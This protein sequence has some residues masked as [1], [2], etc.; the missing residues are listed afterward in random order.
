MKKLIKLLG[1]LLGLVIIAAGTSYGLLFTS[2]ATPI[3]NGLIHLTI[4]PTLSA[5]KVSY[6]AP[7]KFEL[8]RVN[9]TLD[10]QKIHIPKITVWLNSGLLHNGKIALDSLLIDGLHWQGRVPTLPF[11]KH[12]YL[13]QIA[14]NHLDFSYHNL[15]AR[16][17]NLQVKTPIWVTGGQVLPYGHIQAS[18]D[19]LYYHGQAI[20]KVL[21][22]A[23][24]QAKDSTVYGASFTWHGAQVSG[25]AEQY[26][27]GWSL[28]NV[29]AT[30]LNL[31]SKSD[32]NGLNKVFQRLA[33]H[34]HDINSLDILNSSVSMAG[35]QFDNLDLSLENILVNQP[36]W[37]QAKGYLS[38]NADSIDY[39]G[40]QLVQPSG[41]L[42]FTKNNIQIAEFDS[43][44]Q[45]GKVQI[46]GNLQPRALHL[47]LL[48]A[49]GVKWSTDETTDLS[50]LAHAMPPLDSVTIDQLDLENNQ[51]IQLTHRP[52]WQLSGFSVEGSNMKLRHQ[53]HWRLWQGQVQASASS[54]NYGDIIGSHAIIDTHS[55]HGLWVLDRLSVPLQ[56][57]YI[58]ALGRWN[59]SKLGEPWSLDVQADGLPL[60]EPSGADTLPFDLQGIVSMKAKLHGQ[61]QSAELLRYSLTGTLQAGLRD[62]TLAT[63]Q[64]QQEA[65]QSIVVPLTIDDLQANADRGRI[66]INAKQISSTNST[67]QFAGVLDLANMS[68]AS[69]QLTLKQRC[70]KQQLNLISG[71]VITS[72]TCKKSK[73]RRK[74]K[75]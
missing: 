15:I 9:A 68:D 38:F 51:F 28:V 63:H 21:I 72:K 12:L 69:A 75:K 4:S 73:K 42:R 34:I 20:D 52:F 31:T 41:Q 39:R 17:I 49:S 5:Q 70:Q 30:K 13:Y 32:A 24:Y 22:N 57:G 1:I 56:N 35:W 27:A 40:L 18:A 29:T 11:N 37:L 23:N 48:H 65:S 14:F 43:D 10:K 2:L 64:R 16:N 44:F 33:P 8:N 58:N 45:Q 59:L 74:K 53:Q 46:N 7:W 3:V 47:S 54:V 36:V 55:E 26:P 71:E 25:Q 67:G 19:Q 50:W 62:G 61:A 60:P 66:E 6:Q